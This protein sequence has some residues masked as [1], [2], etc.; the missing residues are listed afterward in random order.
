MRLSPG[1][2]EGSKRLFCL[3]LAI[4]DLAGVPVGV[5]GPGSK[6]GEPV[7]DSHVAGGGLDAA[8]RPDCVDPV[9]IVGSPT[10]AR[11]DSW[12]RIFSPQFCAAKL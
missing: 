4:L 6:T 1:T 8:A 10:V 12:V 9:A 5:T 11:T 3:N 2:P 7:N